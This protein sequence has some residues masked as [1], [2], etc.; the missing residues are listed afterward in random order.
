MVARVT[1]SLNVCMTYLYI[2]TCQEQTR[3]TSTIVYRQ[4]SHRHTEGKQAIIQQLKRYFGPSVTFPSRAIVFSSVGK[5]AWQLCSSTVNCKLVLKI[6]MKMNHDKIV[7]HDSDLK[8]FFKNCDTIFLSHHP[9]QGVDKR[10]VE[11]PLRDAQLPVSRIQTSHLVTER[12]IVSVCVCIL[13]VIGQKVIKTTR[14]FPENKV[15]L[16]G[17][18]S[19]H[20]WL[21][22]RACY[23]EE[24]R[25]LVQDLFSF[26]S[27]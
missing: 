25:A 21:C 9:P 4:I 24:I 20:F 23:R 3:I 6:N 14:A 7:D 26:Y 2:K 15:F 10:Y 17:I 22:V 11:E 8:H 19:C 12:H 5:L 18:Y 1:E 16:F 27:Q 13:S